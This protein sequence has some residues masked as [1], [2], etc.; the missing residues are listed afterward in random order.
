[1][2]TKIKKRRKIKSRIQ[3]KKFPISVTLDRKEKNKLFDLVENY[4]R[5]QNLVIA[6]IIDMISKKPEL[7]EFYLKEKG[8]I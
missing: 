7:Y 2:K 5:S 4:Y 8:E 3:G 1:M 6:D